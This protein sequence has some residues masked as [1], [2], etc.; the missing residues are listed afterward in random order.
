MSISKGIKNLTHPL[1]KPNQRPSIAL[2]SQTM[3]SR[4]SHEETDENLYTRIYSNDNH[5]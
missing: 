2:I 4:Y 3:T 1:Y 5:I